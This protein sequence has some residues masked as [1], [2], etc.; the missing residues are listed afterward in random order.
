MPPVI[1]SLLAEAQRWPVFP[2]YGMSW[3]AI[4]E[5][6]NARVAEA[7]GRLCRCGGGVSQVR[8]VLHERARDHV[9]MGKQARRKARWSGSPIG[10]RPLKAAPRSSKGGS[11]K[12]RRMCAARF[13]AVSANPENTTSIPRAFSAVFVYVIQEQ[14]RYAEAEQLQRQVIDIYK[15]LGYADELRPAG[16]RQC[17]PRADFES[18]AQVRRG[19]QAL[20][21]GRCLDGEV[22][23]VAPRGRQRRSCARLHHAHAG[24]L[25]Q[26]A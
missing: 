23:A 6:G 1:V 2:I 10:P 18:R 3:Q 19:D 25:R 11:A 16:Q 8:R 5:D 12:A 9:A 20:R 7:R 26:R 22:G 15:G 21:S 14:G 4:V 17:L 13:S 24:Q